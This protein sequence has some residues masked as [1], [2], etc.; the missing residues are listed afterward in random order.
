MSQ[1][2]IEATANET[3][4]SNNTSLIANSA[5]EEIAKIAKLK[6]D[7][8]ISEEEFTKMKND[9]IDKM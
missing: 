4:A 8:L 1:E 2:E 3:R 7:G 6:V 9:I 5:A